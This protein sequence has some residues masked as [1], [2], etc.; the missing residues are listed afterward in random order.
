[1]EENNLSHKLIPWTLIDLLSI[2]SLTFI[3]VFIIGHLG[4]VFLNNSDL[5]QGELVEVVTAFATTLLQN[6]LLLGLSFWLVGTRYGFSLIDHFFKI[7]KDQVKNVFGKGIIGGLGIFCG[8]TVFNSVLASFLTYF[9]DYQPPQQVIITFLLKTQSSWLFLGYVFLIVL[10]APIV[11]ETFFR[12]LVYSYFREKYGVKMAYFL[13]A[14]L[15]GIAH[16]SA[17]A[18]VGTFLAGLGLAYLFEK[19]KSLITNILAHMVWNG[20]VT[21]FLFFLWISGGNII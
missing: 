4:I 1:M 10:V 14:L 18:F 19:S 6:L 16:Q 21:I 11:E 5:V 9:F 17:W 20:V 15:F 3:L 8:I 2:F 13:S 7:D 12:G